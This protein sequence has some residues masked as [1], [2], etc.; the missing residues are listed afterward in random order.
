MSSLKG[1]NF[2]SQNHQLSLGKTFGGEK[3]LRATIAIPSDLE[4]QVCMIFNH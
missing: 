1:C 2:W 3:V 4:Y